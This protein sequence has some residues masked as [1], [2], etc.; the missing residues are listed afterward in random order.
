MARLSLREKNCLSGFSWRCF[1]AFCM[2]IMALMTYWEVL[3]F[4]IVFNSGISW[5]LVWAS[6]VVCL[7]VVSWVLLAS[8]ILFG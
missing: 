1:H 7:G 3:F 6:Y 8:G 2:V 5:C 4:G